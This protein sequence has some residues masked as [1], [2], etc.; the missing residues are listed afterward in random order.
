MDRLQ[1]IGE[2]FDERAAHYTNGVTDFMGERELRQIRPLVPAGSRVLDYGC[3]TGRNTLDLLRRGCDVTAYD[4]SP[5]MLAICEQRSAAEGHACDFTTDPST[6]E[7]Q[8]WPVVTAIGILDYYPQ[9]VEMIR[10][11]GEHVEPDGLL[12]I[13]FPNAL[14]PLGWAYAAGSRFTLQATPRTPSFATRAVEEAGLRVESVRFAA[15]PVAALALTFVMG[16][17]RR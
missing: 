13:T 6:L 16:V 5:E 15:P 17:R 4:L 10:S 7:G 1:E 14:S 9:P 11:L 2:S 3:G 12:V 8:T